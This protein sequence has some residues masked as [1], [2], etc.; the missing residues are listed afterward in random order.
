MIWDNAMS[1]I[2]HQFSQKLDHTVL[3]Q[4]RALTRIIDIKSETYSDFYSNII[5]ELALNV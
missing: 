5:G 2:F 3:Y 4:S 1:F